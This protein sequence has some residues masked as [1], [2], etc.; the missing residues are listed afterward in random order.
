MDALNA[1]QIVTLVLL[2][3]TSLGAF[4]VLAGLWCFR[5]LPHWVA[6]YYAGAVLLCGFGWEF[7]FAYGWGGGDSIAQRRTAQ[8]NEVIPPWFNGIANALGDA[9]GIAVVGLLLVWLFCGISGAFDR[10][11]WSRFFCAARLV[12]RR[13]HPDRVDG[14][15]GAAY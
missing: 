15:S 14:L 8:M 3:G 5:R 1:L 4:L 9:F 10:W 6:A 13:E 2:Y 12:C 11:K 7:W